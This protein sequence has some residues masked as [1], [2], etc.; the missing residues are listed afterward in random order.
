[1]ALTPCIA[2]FNIWLN[3]KSIFT[4]NHRISNQH[5]VSEKFRR[6]QEQG[7]RL[8]DILAINVNDR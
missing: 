5:I 3:L 7:D 8:R 6:I 2:S 1:V 4:E